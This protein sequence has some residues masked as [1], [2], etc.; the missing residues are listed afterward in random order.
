M[1]DQASRWDLLLDRLEA[2]PWPHRILTMGGVIG[3]GAATFAAGLFI[4]SAPKSA[5]PTL[6]VGRPASMTLNGLTVRDPAA[7]TGVVRDLNN[8]PA[9]PDTGIS[10]MSCPSGAGR[11]YVIAFSYANGDRWTVVVQRDSCQLV[12]A[13]GFW[14]RTGASTALL[15]DLDA[16]DAAR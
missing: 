7:I 10:V 9:Q 2:S 6:V 13:G 8:L 5:T 11:Q 12:M 15:R 3:L 16:L 4:H 14:P 1:R